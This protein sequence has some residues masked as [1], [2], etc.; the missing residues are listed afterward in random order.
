MGKKYFLSKKS[1][2]LLGF[3]HNS[4][5]NIKRKAALAAF[6]FYRDVVLVFQLFSAALAAARRA[7]GTRYGLHE[8]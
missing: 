7:I 3:L 6:L 1:L 5:E 4:A 8:T 2:F